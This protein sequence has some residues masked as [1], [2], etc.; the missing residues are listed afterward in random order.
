M[1][2]FHGSIDG[3]HGKPSLTNSLFLIALA[4][5]KRT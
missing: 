3:I 2:K 5:P 4:N 1:I